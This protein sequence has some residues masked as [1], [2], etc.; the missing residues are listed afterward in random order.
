MSKAKI[1]PQGKPIPW[2]NYKLRELEITRKT[3]PP[4]EQWQEL[5]AGMDVQIEA[6]P[7]W[8]G[9]AYNAGEEWYGAEK[10]TSVLISSYPFCY[11]YL[12]KAFL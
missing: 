9:D 6:S 5:V 11:I 4:F 3:K 1:R 2:V 7:F 12:S 10:A 8:R